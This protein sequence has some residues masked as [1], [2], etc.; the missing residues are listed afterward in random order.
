MSI[1]CNFYYSS[2]YT[3]PT[4]Y[5]I[6]FGFQISNYMILFFSICMYFLNIKFFTDN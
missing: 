4:F 2:D 6:H 3:L 5:N 1:S